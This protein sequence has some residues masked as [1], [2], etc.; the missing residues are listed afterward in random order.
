MRLGFFIATFFAVITSCL[1]S[2]NPVCPSP[3]F[4]L[5]GGTSINVLNTT[6]PISPT[7]P[8]ST[9]IP[10][11]PGNGLTVMNNIFGGTLSPT[12]VSSNAGNYLYW[13]GSAWVTTTV[14]TNGGGVNLG[15]C[16][17]I[18]YSL[19]G[20]NLFAHNAGTPSTTLI[21]SVSTVVADIVPDC[22]CNVYVFGSGGLLR[23]YSPTGTVI[24]T[25]TMVGLPPTVSGG[26]YAIVGNN[27]YCI[28]GVGTL[29]QGTI[30]AGSVINFITLPGSMSS[31]SDWGSCAV[32]INSVPVVAT[33]NVNASSCQTGTITA[34]SNSLVTYSWSGP[35]ITP[36]VTTSAVVTN[37]TGVFSCTV[38]SSGCGVPPT[39]S[40]NVAMGTNTCISVSSTSITCASLGSATVTSP[41]IGPFSYTWNP[42]AQTGSVATN[43]SPG[44]YTIDIYDAFF[45]LTYTATTTF[46][47]LIPLSGNVSNNNVLCNGAAT[48]TANVT[49]LTG[50]SGSQ[51]YLWTNGV[52]T[53]T[54]SSVNGLSS[55][56]WSITV[57]DQLTGC[58]FNQV[59]FVSQPPSLTLTP[60]ANSPSV[61]VGSSITLSGTASG[62]NPGYTYTWTAGPPTSNYTITSLLAGN[63]VYTLNATDQ[64]SCVI[65]NT[66]S[67]DFIPNPTLSVAN[68]SIC[69]LQIGTL[70]V[71]GASTYTWNGTVTASSFTDNPLTTQN[72]TVVGTA[73]SC[74]A[75]ATA[76]IILKTLP[77]PVT[78]PN[79]NVC[80]GKN[81]LFGA[82]GGVNY[83]WTGP[84]S[85]VSATQ[86]NTL[87]TVQINQAGNYQVTVTAAN[88]C[89]A[90]TSF[91][92]NVNVTPLVS[93]APSTTSLCSGFN[94]GANLVSGGTA[95]SFTWLP[96]NGLSSTN[97]PTVNAQPNTTTIYTLRGSLNSCTASAIATVYIVPPPSPLISLSS[98]T[99][100]AQ[101]LNGS[102]NSINLSVSG[103]N[104]YTI[105][106]PPHIGNSNPFGPNSQLTV[107][108]PF[109][110]TGITTVTVSASNGVCTLNSFSSFNIIP[111]PSITI[112]NTVPF[113]C[114]GRSQVLNATGATNFSWV[115]AA[116]GTSVFLTGTSINVSPTIT[117]FYSV[118]GSLN[119]CNSSSENYTLAVNPIPQIALTSTYLCI[120][121]PVE[122]VANGN[123]NSNYTWFPSSWL[124]VVSNSVVKANP[125]SQQTYTVFANLNTC[126]NSAVVTVSVE[127]LPSAN[128]FNPKLT[129][130]QNDS[131]SFTGTGGLSYFWN[132]PLS[133]SS[134]KS[135]V[136]FRVSSTLSEGV[137]TLTV[138]NAK[139]CAGS[140]TTAIEVK[141]LPSGFI[142]PQ[143]SFGCVPFCTEINFI[144]IP[145]S[146]SIVSVRWQLGTKLFSTKSFS[147][148]FL[149]S[150]NYLVT[151]Q[152]TD[153]NGCVGN[154]TQTVVAYPKPIADFTF[155][156]L[157]PIELIE[158]VQFT[159]LTE[160]A[161]QYNWTFNENNI[162][163]NFKNPIMTF[164]KEG[165][166][167]VALSVENKWNCTDSIVKNIKVM[168]DVAVFVPN[169]FTP[170]ADAT[171]EVF[172][173]VL[174]GVFQI[175]F[176][177][178]NRW[179]QKIYE[180]VD[181]AEGWDG[182]YLGKP[183]Q[184]GEYIWKLNFS[185]LGRVST[186]GDILDKYS[187]ELTGKVLLYR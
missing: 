110:P 59:I 81:F 158:P 145:Q 162:T 75:L 72:Y 5:L 177:V 142:K 168:P 129:Y 187:K 28:G 108:S 9:G 42:G 62:G 149:N 94:S 79:S 48:A 109:Q 144:E 21:T 120:G 131:V 116:S 37:S 19:I 105:D 175:S 41:G 80:E 50:G 77:S 170:N 99:L 151:G 126:T 183:C 185:T 17:T 96:P 20:S 44:T 52:T 171:N 112:T 4:Y 148:C 35:G 106:T 24:T 147:N 29:Y 71:S 23:K 92:L 58:V 85:F 133:Y 6:L 128:I 36:P 179:G 125:P 137:Y 159:L 119:G 166:Y 152:L 132:G 124:T 160:D 2:Q 90:S 93:I 141:P 46:N 117:T 180:T 186:N 178:F 16:S 56:S 27:I 182:T 174:R 8:S 63:Y 25:Y 104:S 30:G 150:G 45:N 32:D 1:F 88:G 13:S 49:N 55:G 167:S 3:N 83:N 146:D 140:A 67:V 165:V 11:P 169:A 34:T 64:N 103:A 51:N 127:P 76:S 173:P 53:Y 74:T 60:S 101:N 138:L 68:T 154:I 18:L 47:S 22:D 130:C 102:S 107:L 153:V 157:Q 43:L 161:T 65:N 82:S 84:Q 10:N 69:P 156:P 100:C 39:L 33:I 54:Q 7:N 38:F 113:I 15:G 98:G 184:S 78:T 134:N 123:T 26:G 122:L 136:K 73:L 97:T 86:N 12:F 121:T 95:T 87:L 40:L 164:E 181:V 163:S 31:G 118:F 14:T 89:T 91:S 70:T 155:S 135:K 66:I 114:S 143:K 61:C 115:S 139:N 176:S 172:K 111:N 57:T